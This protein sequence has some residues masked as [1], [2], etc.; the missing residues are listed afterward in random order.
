MTAEPDDLVCVRDGS[1]SEVQ[2]WHDLL[3][4]VEIDSRVV[5]DNLSVGLGTSVPDTVEL[6]VHRGNAD[7]ADTAITVAGRHLQ[8]E[9]D[10]H[11]VPL[12]GAPAHRPHSGG[13]PPAWGSTTE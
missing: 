11:P 7:A 3:R 10:S 1:S 4:A 12:H 9:P 2:L 6:W 5:G 13:H 8:C